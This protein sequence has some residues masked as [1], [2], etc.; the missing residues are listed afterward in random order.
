MS[1]P[2]VRGM[3]YATMR[4]PRLDKGRTVP[5]V[6]SDMKFNQ[7]PII[8]GDSNN[9]MK[10]ME[11]GETAQ[12]PVQRDVKITSDG[13]FL[14]WVIFFSR[15]VTV[16][17]LQ[18]PDD[19]SQSLLQVVK[20]ENNE[21]LVIRIALLVDSIGLTTPSFGN[22]TE[23]FSTSNSSSTE[24][25]AL[26]FTQDEY[27]NYLRTYA[28]FY[29]GDETDYSFDVDDDA[30]EITTGIDWNVQDMSSLNHENNLIM[31]AIPHHRDQLD[32][33]ASKYCVTS[34]LGPACLV[35]ANSW[36]LKYKIPHIDFNAPRH[37]DAK[38][39]PVLI[40]RLVTD[41][42]FEVPNNYLLGDGGS[43]FSGKVF[44]KL[45]RIILVAQEV[46]DICDDADESSTYYAACRSNQSNKP[47][48][49][50][51][52][53]AVGRLRTSVEAWLG[54]DATNQFVFDPY[55]GGIISCGCNWDGERCFNTAPDCPSVLDSYANFGNGGY[56]CF[57]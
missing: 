41:L 9:V 34:L 24:N 26:Q 15:P 16:Q 50:I 27:E 42:E 14:T 44:A 30:N 31:F 33:S 18:K 38:Y 2:I 57:L 39:M 11:A 10:C 20:D 28:P 21:E 51:L 7:P 48:K 43:Y 1:S 29:P 35:R 49:E 40:Q 17:C 13:S 56:Y 52:K 5:T 8:D 32:I 36:T 19:D 46:M 47:T 54:K 23:S 6:S 22:S 12:A 25:G 55:W 4:Y 53:N 3:P 45:A 37:P